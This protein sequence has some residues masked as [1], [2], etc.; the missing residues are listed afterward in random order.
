MAV[1]GWLK[2][3]RGISLALNM[4][5][6]ISDLGY[7]CSSNVFFS[8]L[9]HFY[10]FISSNGTY[11]SCKGEQYICQEFMKSHLSFIK[12]T[13]SSLFSIHNPVGVKL[14]VR[15][16]LNFSH[17]CKHKFRHNFHDTLNPLCFCSLELE[18][19][20]RYLLRCRIFASA[21]L[22]LMNDLDL[23]DPTISQLNE[24]ALT[25]ILLYGDSKKSA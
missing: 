10:I 6:S 2:I 20:Q 13:Y 7:F 24:T 25:N 19:T 8:S 21:R 9:K 3:S 15:L 18:T 14:F 22:A 12:P 5:A 11:S 23:I 17:L 16:R 1:F 4:L